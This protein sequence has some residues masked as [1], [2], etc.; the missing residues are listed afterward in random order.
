M[1]RP[2]F[3]ASLLGLAGCSAKAHLQYD[4]GRAYL[5]T[6]AAQADR[7]RTTATDGAYALTGDEGLELRQRVVESATDAE[8]GKAEAVDSIRVQ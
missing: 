5:A 4:H 2:L 6:T 8:S 7:T 3:A 1:T